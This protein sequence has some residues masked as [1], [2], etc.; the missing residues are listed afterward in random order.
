MQLVKQMPQTHG[1]FFFRKDV[2]GLTLLCTT[3]VNLSSCL[4][5]VVSAVSLCA[6]SY[7]WI[8]SVLSPCLPLLVILF[9]W[10]TN[11]LVRL[12]GYLSGL[13]SQ[14]LLFTVYKP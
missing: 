14:L 7:S 6:L 2:D 3:L 10:F 1:L 11:W 12:M 13:L 9:I 8:L 5:C 4:N